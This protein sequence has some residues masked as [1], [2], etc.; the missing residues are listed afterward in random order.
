M[1]PFVCAVC[2]QLITDPYKQLERRIEYRDVRGQGR[3]AVLL[4]AH[5]CKD[6]A[7]K[8]IAVRRPKTDQGALL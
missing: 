6:C 2:Q 7:D 1:S 3:Y 4:D 5:L 8:E